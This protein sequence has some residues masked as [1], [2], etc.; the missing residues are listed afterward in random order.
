MELNDKIPEKLE[1][2]IIDPDEEIRDDTVCLEI[3]EKSQY[4][5]VLTLGNFSAIIGKAKSRKS[6]F[7][8][9]ILGIMVAGRIM[10]DKFCPRIR[11]KVILFDTEQ[12]KTRVQRSLQRV[13]K[14]A[15]NGKDFIAY[16]LRPFTVEE[17]IQMIQFA[18]YNTENVGFVLLD[19][20][21]DLVTD[22]N[23]PDQATRISNLLMKWTEERN[24]HV[25][26]VIHQNKADLSAR[27]HIGTEI[28]NKSETVISITKDS[29][30]KYKSLITPE[31][32]RGLEFEPFSYCI[33]DGIPLLLESE[34]E[35]IKDMP[36]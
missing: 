19:G 36:F 8:I 18:I 30:E 21:R 23:S 35:E 32:T 26:V 5:P 20:V 3:I 24:I 1:S 6:F 34:V 27:G 31:F 15:G 16:N 4:I 28:I 14:I 2:A 33:E 22:I 10:F 29:V 17:R 9:L 7:G 11:K 25:M 13:I 12:G